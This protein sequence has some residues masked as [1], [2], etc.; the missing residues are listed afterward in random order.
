VGGTSGGGGRQ[1][2]VVG[3]GSTGAAQEVVGWDEEQGGGAGGASPPAPPILGGGGAAQGAAG[4]AAVRGGSPT[5]GTQQPATPHHHYHHSHHPLNPLVVVQ[6]SQI[7]SVTSHLYRSAPHRVPGY[8]RNTSDPS[9]AA[10]AAAVRGDRSVTGLSRGFLFQGLRQL[11]RSGSGGVGAVGGGMPRTG[12]PPTTTPAAAAGGSFGSGGGIW[13]TQ[14]QQQPGWAVPL[15]DDGAGSEA[16]GD[17]NQVRATG[18]PPFAIYVLYLSAGLRVAAHD[19][20]LM[21]P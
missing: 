5:R 9:T 17:D 10:A 12:W 8:T 13:G 15:L 2:G 19:C 6:V 11:M 18:S 20:E 16:C 1:T 21:P 3:G 14:Q 7:G 4:A